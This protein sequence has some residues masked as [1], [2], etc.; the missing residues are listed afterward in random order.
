MNYR[1]SDSL[2]RQAS[3]S[4][5][6]GTI[7]SRPLTYLLLHPFMP[8]VSSNRRRT[9]VSRSSKYEDEAVPEIQIPKGRV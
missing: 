9:D 1:I 4:K 5:N 6:L 2:A 8:D 3:I 7:P